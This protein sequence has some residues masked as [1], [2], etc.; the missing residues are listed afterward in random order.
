[1]MK[2]CDPLVSGP[3]L[4]ID[5]I[6]R[7]VCYVCDPITIGYIVSWTF[8]F[9]YQVDLGFLDCDRGQNSK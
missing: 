9:C 4:A 1:M 6:P 3:E 8:F 2:N 7:P 5:T